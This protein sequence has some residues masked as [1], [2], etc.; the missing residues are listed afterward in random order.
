MHHVND[1]LL[2]SFIHL[3]AHRYRLIF[4]LDSPVVTVF[5]KQED[6]AVGYNPRYRDKKSYGPL[7]CGGEFILPPGC[8]APPLKCRNLGWQH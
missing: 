5:E 2:Q 3:P 1:R 6:A 7:L 4:D 8:R